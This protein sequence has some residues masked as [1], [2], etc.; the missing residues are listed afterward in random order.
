MITLVFYL[1]LHP[2]TSTSAVNSPTPASRLAPTVNGV[3]SRLLSGPFKS[4]SCLDLPRR[5]VSAKICGRHGV[6]VKSL[7]FLQGKSMRDF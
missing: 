5:F 2:Q 6:P 1:L 4:S 7:E 3:S